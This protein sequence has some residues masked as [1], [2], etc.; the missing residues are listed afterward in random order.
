MGLFGTDGVRGVANRDLT[1]SL[2][3]R[4]GAAF[5]VYVKRST[6]GVPSVLVAKDPRVSSDMLE[7][8]LTAGLASAGVHCLTAGIVPTPAVSHLVQKEGLAGGAM[9]SASHNPVEDN[10]IKFFSAAGEKLLEADEAEIERMCET[11]VEGAEPMGVGTIRPL[12][13]ARA[14]YVE[15]LVGRYSGPSGRARIVALDCAFGAT[16]G[17]AREVFER[18]GAKV[19]AIGDV[20]DGSRINVE[21]GATNTAALAGVM[22]ENQAFCGFAFDGDGDRVMTLDETRAIFDGDNAIASFVKRRFAPAA[23]PGVRVAIGTPYSNEGLREALAGAGFELVRA[24][25]GDRYVYEELKRTGAPIGGEPS[26]HL[27]FRGESRTGDGI[28]SALHLLALALK[29]GVPMSALQ[30]DMR[31]YPQVM[32]NLKL[33]A[34][35]KAGWGERPGAQEAIRAAEAELQGRGRVLVRASGTEPLLRILVEAES[36]ALAESV[37]ARLSSSLLSVL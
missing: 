29:E 33:T 17:V 7:A 27:I 31:R 37:A 32:Q 15:F 34:E 18:L 25:A 2:A 5:G 10:G 20:H 19:V 28:L 23:D 1:A 16:A 22:R 9:I 6:D 26:G 35:Q 21:C 11:G 4:L 30:R 8:A 24:K 14:G 13:D 3:A 12:P 36:A